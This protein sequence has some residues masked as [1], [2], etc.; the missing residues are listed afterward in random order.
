MSGNGSRLLKN[1]IC[2]KPA[3]FPELFAG[4]CQVPV[5]VVIAAVKQLKLNV[6]A[7]Q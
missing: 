2:D 5:F 4:E 1:V 6:D 3:V 7:V